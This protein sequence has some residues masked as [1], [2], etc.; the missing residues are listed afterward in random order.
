M[1]KKKESRLQ[2]KIRKALQKECGGIWV[3]IHGGPFQR[4]GLPD[5]DGMVDTFSFRFEVKVPLEGK[6]TDLQLETLHDYR[7]EGCIAC[8]VETPEQ[9]ISLVKA[10]TSSPGKRRKGRKLYKWIC[11]TLCSAHGEDLGYGRGTTGNGRQRRSARW[12]EDQS[13]K[14]LGEVLHGKDGRLHGMP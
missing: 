9:A 3:K 11:D 12:A 14:Y 5:L 4:S 6:P 8:I 1:A 10:A 2:L 13:R 7:A